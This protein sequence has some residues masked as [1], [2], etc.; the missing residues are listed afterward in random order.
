MKRVALTLVLAGGLGATV[1]V[2]LLEALRPTK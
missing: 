1:A 2:M